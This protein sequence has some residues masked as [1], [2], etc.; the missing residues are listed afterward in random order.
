MLHLEP[1]S[2][3]DLIPERTTRRFTHSDTSFLLVVV[4]HLL[5]LPRINYVLQESNKVTGLSDTEVALEYNPSSVTMTNETEMRNFSFLRDYQWSGGTSYYTSER[6]HE[7]VVGSEVRIK[8]VQSSNNLT[9]VANS[10]CS[11]VNS[12]LLVSPVLTHSLSLVL[13]SILV[14]SLIT[15]L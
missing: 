5:V 12:Q 7:L 8:N 10:T 13:P 11:M 9:G 6:P 4:S 3:E 14:L 15:H 1:S 2:L